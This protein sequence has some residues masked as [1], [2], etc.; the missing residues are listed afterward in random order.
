MPFL[1]KK[2]P[3]TPAQ[4][5]AAARKAAARKRAHA[6]KPVKGRKRPAGCAPVKKKTPKVTPKAAPVFVATNPAVS[7]AQPL[8]APAVPA[9]PL[10]APVPGGT[11]PTTS[12]GPVVVDTP[13]AGSFG[14][15]E[16][17]R[18]LWRAGFGP[19]PGDVDRLVAMGLDAA[20]ASLVR[21][22]GEARLVGP[23]PHDADGHA[24][25]PAD[26][27]GHDHC[28]WLDRMVRSDQPLVERM[29]LVWHDWFATSS[30]KVGRTQLMLDQNQTFRRHALGS[31][32]E[33]LTAVTKDPAMLVWLDGIGNRAGDPNENHAR[34]LMELFT[35]GAGRGAY[36]EADVRELARVMT[37]WTATWRSGI[38]W[39]DFTYVPSRH[40]AGTKAVFGRRG[41]FD[42]DDAARLCLENPFHPSFLVAKL[43]GAFVAEPLPADTAAALA[44]GYVASG[45][46]IAPVVEAI[47]KHP[48]FYGGASL[49]KPPVVFTAGVL[50]M[51]G[52]GV[53]STDWAWLGNQAGQQL[54]FPP[55]VAGWDDA[56]WLD[57]STWRARWN[58]VVWAIHDRTIDPWG[59]TPYSTTETPAE[60][61]DRVLA[62]A[63]AP[64]VT[65]EQRAALLAFAGAAVAPAVAAWQLGPY[66]AQRQ[67][68][69]RLLL[70]TSADWQVA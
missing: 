13:V 22:A 49:A 51:A 15:A 63:G 7:A 20:V 61:V 38:G 52:R 28:W 41:A 4:K 6:C 43:W 11:T 31:F 23:E 2:K 30:E 14:R 42:Y 62:W 40:D 58:L 19:R 44:E 9:A 70:L 21:P 65:A 34:E 55:N 17:E 24:L 69:L 54:F 29:T 67:N 33:L 16:A 50:R 27:W 68:A 26:L 47:L 60:A 45:F 18:L 64:Q 5:R 57:T 48:L 25:A 39:T 10:P 66:R 53:E 12:P 59:G 8:P 37:G 46:E 32:R 36:G 3:L 56:A 1:A 35:L